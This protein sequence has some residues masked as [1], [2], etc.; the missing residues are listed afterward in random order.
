MRHFL[1]F[2]M[3]TLDEITSKTLILEFTLVAERMMASESQSEERRMF[4]SEDSLFIF[5]DGLEHTVVFAFRTH[6]DTATDRDFFL[7][8]TSSTVNMTKNKSMRRAILHFITNVRSRDN[9]TRIF[10]FI[11][12]MMFKE[13]SF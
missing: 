10:K 9:L 11:P 7:I 12:R 6:A 5:S 1:E 8:F 4:H 13:M 3:E 2:P